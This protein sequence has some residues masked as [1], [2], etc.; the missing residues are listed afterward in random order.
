MNYLTMAFL[1]L[2]MC[3]WSISDVRAEGFL[4]N[5]DKI[6]DRVTEKFEQKAEDR[7]NESA[8]KAVDSF[9]DSTDQKVDCTLNGKGCPPDTPNAQAMG[10]S[11]SPSLSPS[12]NG[13]DSMKCLATDVACLKKAQSLG[14]QVKI[15]DEKDLDMMRCEVT[16]VDCLKKAKSLGIQVEII[17]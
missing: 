6:M 1:S 12:R 16:D 7:L 10:A 13:S 9:F 2:I 11:A 14:Q 4:D 17:D 5:L 15:V 8:E 3:L